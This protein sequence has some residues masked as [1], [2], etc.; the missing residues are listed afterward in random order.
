[1]DMLREQGIISSEQYEQLWSLAR[2]RFSSDQAQVDLIEGRLSRLR[3][4]DV[5]VVG[6]KPTDLEF[7]SPDG[8]WTM[9]I[10]G[11]I[12]ARYENKDS[13]AEAQTGQ[14][15]SVPRARLTFDGK[16]G[17]ENIRYKLELDAS[18]NS[19]ISTDDQQRDVRV[20]DAW[21][22]WAMA[23]YSAFRMGQYRFPFGR[24][25]AVNSGALAL[26]STS[27]AYREFAPG[28]EPGAMVHGRLADDRLDYYTAV[29]NGD[30]TGDANAAGESRDGLR[31]G[32]RVV[33]NPLGRMRADGSAFQTEIEGG[34]RV[35]LGGSYMVNH[36]SVGKN[37]VAP[38]ANTSTAGAEF[39]LFTGPLSLQAEH[40]D[41]TSELDGGAKIDDSGHTE[42]VG[43][44][45][46]KDVWELVARHSVIDFDTKTDQTETTLGLNFYRD[47]HRNQWTLEYAWLNDDDDAPDARRIRLQWQVMF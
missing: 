7:R 18:T 46:F 27:I 20:A 19:N 2:Q 31:D 22:D 10:K 45:L 4:P 47:E 41:R 35:A 38:G 30:G 40:Y 33:W 25:G 24:E 32:V 15:F 9:G 37:T 26:T 16:A 28:R 6:G 14:N 39:Q 43:C 3:A 13:D 36:D 8:K 23:A 11:R 29:S 17:A 21:I 5:Q 42:Q 34:T 12:Q 44:F 1:M